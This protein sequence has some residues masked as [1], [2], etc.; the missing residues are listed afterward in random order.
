MGFSKPCALYVYC[1][2]V[3]TLWSF[4]NYW[5]FVKYEVQPFWLMG[6]WA[7]G[8]LSNKQCKGYLLKCKMSCCNFE[9]VVQSENAVQLAEYRHT[10]VRM[11]ASACLPFRSS[12]GPVPRIRRKV[13]PVC[14]TVRCKAQSSFRLFPCLPLLLEQFQWVKD[15]YNVYALQGP[16]Q[17]AKTAFV[18]S[19]FKLPLVLT[20]Q[21]Q[22]VLNLQSFRYGHR[23]ALT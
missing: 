12:D 10:V 6:W 23:N 2:K 22:D 19:L 7:T 21:G 4:T 5:P 18:K 20:I 1:S 13:F 17:A 8:K 16:S 14:A 15:R 9:A 11:L 3:C